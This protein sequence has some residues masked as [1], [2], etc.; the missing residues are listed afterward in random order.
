MGGSPRHLCRHTPRDGVTA[1]RDRLLLALNFGGTK[2]E[3]IVGRR[4]RLFFL[5]FRGTSF[6]EV[7]E[8]LERIREG[9]H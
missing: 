7:K 8:A 5:A 9:S 1:K 4:G 2:D 6:P 3:S